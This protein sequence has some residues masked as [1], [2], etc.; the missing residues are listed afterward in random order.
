MGAIAT[1]Q[2]PAALELFRKITLASAAIPGAFPP[3][4]IDVTVDGRA[5]QEMH[6]DGGASRQVFLYP[7]PSIFRPFRGKRALNASGTSTSFATPVWTPTG[8]VSIAGS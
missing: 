2:D 3:V 5:Y 4:M 7:P 8:P 1:S 6:V